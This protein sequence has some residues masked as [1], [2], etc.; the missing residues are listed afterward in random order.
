MKILL[1]IA[2]FTMGFSG[3]V[4]QM[5]LLRELL[6]VFS[7]NEFSIGIILANWLIL[8]AFGCFFLGKKAENI[9]YK[10]ET[11]SGITIIF[12]L[13]LPVA[14]YL[15]RILK[16]ILGV[17]IGENIGFLPMLYSSFLI[18]L[19]V[20]VSHGMLFTFSCKLY[21]MFST[22]DAD[23]IGKVYV[24]ETIGTICA[25]LV[26]TYLFIPYL[27]SFKIA[28]GLAIANFFI[29]IVLLT[30]S[31]ERG[32]AIKTLSAISALLFFLFVYGFSAG[33]AD[34][35]HHLSIQSQWKD[36]NLVHYQNS[37]YGNICVIERE[38]QY[39][40][41]LNG[42]AELI[43][44]VPDIAFIEEFV[45]LPLLAHP[46]P[47]SVLI[48]SGGVGGVISEILKHPSIELVEY[49]ELDPLLLEL[50]R[51][52]STPL[53]DRELTDGRIR[54][55]HTDGRLFIKMTQTKYDLILIGLSNPSDLQTNRF[56]TREFFKLAGAKLND[57][58]ILVMSLPGS[59]AYINAELKNLNSC[60]FHTLNSVFSSVK[61]FPGAGTNL[62][63][64]SNSKENF[65][66]DRTRIIN[67][68]NERKIKSEV[69]VPWYIEQ[70]LHPGWQ[71]WFS[72]YLI[73]GTRKINYDHKPL[74]VF[75]IISYWN[76]LFAPY[77]S[78]FF[79]VIEKLELWMFLVV[80]MLFFVVFFW[81]RHK[82]RALFGSAV[83]LCIATT[84]FAGMLV[85]L[86]LIYTFQSIYGY[87]F[88][89]IG[90]LVTAF[91]AGAA[92]GALIITIF[93]S[94]IKNCLNVFIS[95]DFAITCFCFG[96][97]F[98]FLIFSP[99]SE[100]SGVSI[101]LKTLFLCLSF[102]SGMLTGSQFPLA[103]KLSLRENTN[104]SRTAGLIYAS[105]IIGGWVGGVVGGVILLPVLGLLGSCVVVVL[106]KL[107]SFVLLTNR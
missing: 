97:P 88:S 17:S 39:L 76:A 61:V 4:A 107:S 43:I 47:K 38:K 36:H 82:A 58:G 42:V 74:A 44:P 103:S 63:L 84:G 53:T 35:L 106:L 26:W 33:G 55:N 10:I 66:I 85:D 98:V 20:S 104:F 13:F 101:F 102:I 92:A 69:L 48:L 51:K 49:V 30:G 79:R 83:P 3:L 70:K 1:G 60:I 5:L 80:F 87:V 31:I 37:I 19:P 91:M 12:S 18:L 54:V 90:L 105:D 2:I 78:W 57:N 9:K 16:R 24:Y 28:V 23:S 32:R 29:L 27:H 93:L 89:W 7:G 72:Q 71:D 8:E 52:F 65:Y 62:F 15:T 64:A 95:I 100:L 86:A 22:R 41:F 46:E 14:V 6:I 68:L 94:R 99:H 56:F 75:Y 50:V 34:K 77:L 73:G 67:K 21:S 96:L 81:F 40:F 11:F 59:L 45:H 25:G